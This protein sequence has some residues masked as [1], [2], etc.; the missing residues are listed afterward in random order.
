MA[1]QEAGLNLII[2]D[3]W[4]KL[5]ECDLECDNVEECGLKLLRVLLNTKM[6]SKF[7]LFSIF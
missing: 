6:D 7:C 5:K 1:E 3:T 4:I 2:I